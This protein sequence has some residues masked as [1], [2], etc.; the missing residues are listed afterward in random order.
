M[1]NSSRIEIFKK[2]IILYK[3]LIKLL[4]KVL[5]LSVS[6]IVFFPKRGYLALFESNV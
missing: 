3:Y 4:G 1:L 2:G 5:F 6:K